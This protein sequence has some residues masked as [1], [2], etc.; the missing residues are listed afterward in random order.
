MKNISAELQSTKLQL[1]NIKRVIPDEIFQNIPFEKED[2][3]NLRYDQ[4]NNAFTSADQTRKEG[5]F[6]SMTDSVQS[7]LPWFAP[8]LSATIESLEK[9]L[10]CHQQEKETIEEH[11]KA[12]IALLS[13]FTSN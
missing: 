8:I 9:S 11:V 13:S 10:V 12:E 3:C 4:S 5:F 6:R 7:Y 2:R 1:T